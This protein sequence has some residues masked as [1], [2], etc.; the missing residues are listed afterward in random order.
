MHSQLIEVS[1]YPEPV[2][3]ARSLTA[4]AY[5]RAHVLPWIGYILCLIVVEEIYRA[6]DLPV[7]TRLTCSGLLA[8]CSMMIA[9]RTDEHQEFFEEG[10]EAEFFS[11]TEELVDKVRFYLSNESLREQIACNGYRRCL[12]AGYSYK[13]RLTKVLAELN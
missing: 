3:D 5:H 9:D 10:K 8:C 7:D 13:N 4:E 1:R 2:L 6:L 12:T 11:S